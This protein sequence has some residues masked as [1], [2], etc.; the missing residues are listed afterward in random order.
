MNLKFK[1]YSDNLI[2]GILLPTPQLQLKNARIT[3]Y[4]G[5]FKKDMRQQVYSPGTFDNW[6]FVYTVDSKNKQYFSL[7][8]ILFVK[9]IFDN[10][11]LFFI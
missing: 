4:N 1:I 7:K 2:D 3:P 5:D 11:N 9:I 8:L 6:V 10:I